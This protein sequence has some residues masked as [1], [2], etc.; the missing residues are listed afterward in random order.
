MPH[1]PG[2]LRRFFVPSVRAGTLL[3]AMRELPIVD[4]DGLLNH[5]PVLVLAPHPD[6]ETLGCG[7]F[8][9]E[10]HA[11]GRNVHVLILTDGT[12]SH[13][14]SKTYPP[15]RL[16]SL[17]AT[18]ARMAIAALN[19]PEDR[20]GFLGF[21]DG[22]LPLRGKRMSSAAAR[23]AAYARERGVGT[24]CTTWQ[25]DPHHDHRAAYILGRTASDELGVK[26]LC[27]PVWGWTVPT[28]AWLPATVVRGGRLDITNQL[29]SKQLAIDCYRSQT[30]DLIGDDPGGFRLSP[31]V[32]AIFRSPFEVLV[33]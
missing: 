18:E 21:P 32:L 30:S 26:L 15:P 33:E 1:I 22:R 3:Q 16:A 17:R 10:C 31:E 2:R 24:I 13:R 4:L 23:I 14:R 6:D 7:G 9:A 29:A 20:I 25:H 8:I 12:G 27:Y 11:R 5:R 28:T 19:L